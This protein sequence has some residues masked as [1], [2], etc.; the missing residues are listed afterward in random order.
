MGGYTPWPFIPNISQSLFLFTL[1]LI[2]ARQES[3]R[4][5]D[6]ALI[7]I[8]IGITFLGHPV[9]AIVLTVIVMAV[10][11][12]VRGLRFQTIIWLAIVAV[13]QL[14]VMSPYLAPIALHYPVGIVNA[15]SGAWPDPLMQPRFAAI[16]RA[17]LVNMP[18]LLAW[19]CSCTAGV[20][21]LRAVQPSRW[22]RG[23][24]FARLS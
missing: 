19:V 11:F 4:W 10:A 14:A 12:G 5:L 21:G 8:A 1:W 17:A 24:S 2:L 22:E 15:A 18:G 13:V 20:F 23:S 16:A 7:G 9:P 3:D 6:A